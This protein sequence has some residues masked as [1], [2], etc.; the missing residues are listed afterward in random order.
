MVTGRSAGT[1][2]SNGTSSCFKTLRSA[3]SGSSR[4]TG[5]SSRDLPSSTKI[6]VATA[7]IGL[8]IEEMDPDQRGPACQ[9]PSTFPA[10]SRNVATQR[11][12]SG[13]GALTTSPPCA[14]IRPRVA[15]MPLT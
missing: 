9:T 15:S 4:S 8:V 5:S 1:V 6:I 13:Y 3:I 10:G 2:S 14:A 7:V 11:F 12:P